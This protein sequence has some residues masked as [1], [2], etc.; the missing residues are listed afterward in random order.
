M[1]QASAFGVLWHSQRAIWRPL[2]GARRLSRRGGERRRRVAVGRRGCARSGQPGHSRQRWT[3][4]RRSPAGVSQQFGYGIH[5]LEMSALRRCLATSQR[6]QALWPLLCCRWPLS[7][8]DWGSLARFASVAGNEAAI[9]YGRKRLI[10]TAMMASILIGIT[11]GFVG[12]V[13]YGLAAVLL[14]IY[15]IVIWLDP[16]SLTAGTAGTAETSRRG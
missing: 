16:S 12:S 11:I 9:R 7:R 3:R 13:S 5:R 14:M 2:P 1:R 10:V 15:G 4:A 6:A 8:S